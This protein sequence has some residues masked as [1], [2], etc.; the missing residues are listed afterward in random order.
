MP[1]TTAELFSPQKVAAASQAAQV[2]TPAAPDAPLP[3]LCQ[4]RAAKVAAADFKQSLAPGN[5][6]QIFNF[7]CMFVK[8][9]VITVLHNYSYRLG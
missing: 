1:R 6:I 9:C 3:V 2:T 7:E 8:A 5:T 4:S